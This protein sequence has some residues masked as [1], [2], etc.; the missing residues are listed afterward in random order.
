MVQQLR[1]QKNHKQLL[2]SAST[3]SIGLA[4]AR[5]LG[6]EYSDRYIA[7]SKPIG[8]AMNMAM[9]VIK[10]VPIKIGIAPNSSSPATGSS[11]RAICGL[12]CRPKRKSVI[13]IILKNS[14]VSMIKESTIPIVV[15]MA[16]QEA[17]NHRKF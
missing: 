13:L 5:I 4:I 16:T 15:I 10:I 1:L 3:S 11:R 2:N 17:K 8:T 7:D 6:F 9:S 14:I 12:H